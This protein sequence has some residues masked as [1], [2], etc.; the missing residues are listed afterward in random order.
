MTNHFKI[1]PKSIKT[2]RKSI[3]SIKIHPKSMQNRYWRRA[4]QKVA[5]SRAPHTI[6]LD[7]F[8]SIFT[9]NRK[10]YLKG[11]Q[12]EAK[13]GKEGIKK[14]MQKS[15]LKKDRK[16]CQKPSKIMPKWMPRSM[17]NRCDFRTCDF[18]VLAESITL[19]T[20]LLHQTSIPNR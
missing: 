12:M 19:K 1:H 8:G 17:E 16:L 3:Q 13:V 5:K 11:A 9:K 20:S 6:V 10:D 14:Q 15:M 18:S 2:H 7:P 4:C